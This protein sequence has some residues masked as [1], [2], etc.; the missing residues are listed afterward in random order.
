MPV[1]PFV[2]VLWVWYELGEQSHTCTV[3]LCEHTLSV[4]AVRI[5]AWV[6]RE[7]P[8][9]SRSA[10]ERFFTETTNTSSW[11]NLCTHIHAQAHPPLW[12]Q[13]LPLIWDTCWSVQ[14]KRF[15]NFMGDCPNHIP[16]F[17]I[18]LL[19]KGGRGTG[20]ITIKSQ[21]QY[22]HKSGI[23]HRLKI[24]HLFIPFLNM[25]VEMRLHY[26]SASFQL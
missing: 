7:S 10:L 15:A 25:T 22:L 1:G 23:L 17:P 8:Y 2:Y 5:I 24:A 20:V 11:L 18:Y 19:S 3:C 14:E 6:M 12:V 16:T 4:T 21:K 9:I 13:A 26:A